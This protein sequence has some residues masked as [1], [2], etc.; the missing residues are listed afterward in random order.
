MPKTVIPMP[1]NL[2]EL[3]PEQMLQLAQSLTQKLGSAQTPPQ[4]QS[5]PQPEETPQSPT[6][7][8]TPPQP[9]APEQPPVQ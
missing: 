4:E 6:E 9:S 1:S 2:S 8:Q 7:E 3:T 5:Q